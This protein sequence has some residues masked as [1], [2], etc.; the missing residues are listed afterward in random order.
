MTPK[1]VARLLLAGTAIPL[2][3]WGACLPAT[4]VNAQPVPAAVTALV[5]QEPE[6]QG[7]QD[8]RALTGLGFML[9]QAEDPD[10]LRPRR[11]RRSRDAERDT[12]SDGEDK[13]R[14]RR[15]PPGQQGRRSPDEG[16]RPDRSQEPGRSER[17]GNLRLEEGSEP[18]RRQER[19][20]RI[21]RPERPERAERSEP[22]RQPESLEPPERRGRPAQLERPERLDPPE[23]LQR[24]DKPER[25]D[26]PAQLERPARPE[27]PQRLEQP[28][29]PERPDR[30]ERRQRPDQ[31][32]RPAVPRAAVPEAPPA[33]PPAT[34]P[35]LSPRTPSPEESPASRERRGQP[36]R[37]E[38]VEGPQ[39][40]NRD[41]RNRTPDAD[42]PASRETTP[43]DVP[44]ERQRD[45]SLRDERGRPDRA[46]RLERLE[47][48]DLP[49]AAPPAVPAPAP[50]TRPAVGAPRTPSAPDEF[51]E[52][53]NR[54][55]M[56]RRGLAPE[57]GFG[58]RRGVR[59]DELRDLRR[60]RSEQGGRRVIIEEQD[61]VIVREGGRYIIR[62]DET[63]RFRR[64][65]EGADIRRERRGNNEVTIVRRPNQVEIIT[66]RDPEGNL[67]RRVRR[68]P[69]GREIVLIEN[70]VERRP[71]G[72]TIIEET[73]RL[74]P[75]QIRIPR[76]KYVVEVE[77]ASQ[78]DLYEAFTAPPVERVE[79]S[80]TLNEVR[81]SPAVR[82]RVRRV[83]VD[84]ITFDFGS[85]E[86]SEEQ[87][88]ALTGVGQALQRA[89]ERNPAEVFL[90]E[91]HTDAVGSEVDNLTLSDR[92][93]E[94]VASVLTQ[95]FG[96]PAENLTTQG[97]GEQYLKV[98]TQEPE[99]ANRRVTIRR[100]TP[101]LRNEARR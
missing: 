67:V 96:V 15:V 72:R 98:S 92:R 46:E 36:E 62:H 59:I 83:D 31:P 23:R 77:S 81:R 57:P 74:P 61:R 4:R 101:L 10:E 99:R 66:V 6:G 43:R 51:R 64:S 8:S 85:W 82:E 12:G 9:A 14:S 91:G 89:I 40:E 11:E 71:R 5:R 17:P 39:R 25:Q 79:R 37:L 16:D 30:Q 13:E 69:G 2:L 54:R 65:Y 28:D 27:R 75:P 68:E 32:Q 73:V 58:D 38:P 18:P 1:R 35:R 42:T 33:V 44:A 94:T 88:R 56:D 80:Y 3:A 55:D 78:E 29:E 20:D 84:T 21:E 24:Q 45:R 7:G 49:E 26:R 63:D 93:A 95:M 90:I 41:R 70:E 97:Y 86:L 22:V 76:E 47:R 48:Q 34:A 100:I 87:G 19:R 60:E 50:T 52:D 53:F